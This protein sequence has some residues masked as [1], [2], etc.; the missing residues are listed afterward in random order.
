MGKPTATHLTHPYASF[1][2]C[3]LQEMWLILGAYF[4]IEIPFLLILSFFLSSYFGGFFRPFLLLILVFAALNF[5]VLLKQTAAFIG[6]LRKGR[7]PGYV[8]LK[9]RG[10]LHQYLGFSMPYVIRNGQWITRRKK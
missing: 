7:P 10:L 2:G 5:F 1:F 3:T 6:R 8:T 9:V 4:L